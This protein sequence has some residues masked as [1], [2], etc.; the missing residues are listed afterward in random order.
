MQWQAAAYLRL[1]ELYLRDGDYDDAVY[2]YERALDLEPGHQ[3]ALYNLAVASLRGGGDREQRAQRAEEALTALDAKLP[4]SAG[5]QAMRYAADFNRVLAQELVGNRGRALEA[6][7]DLARRVL[8]DVDSGTTD[9][10]VERLEGPATSMLAR[11]TGPKRPAPEDRTPSRADLIAMLETGKPTPMM[12]AAL[13][14]FARERHGEDARTSYDL[15]LLSASRGDP[16]EALDHLEQAVSHPMVKNLV[17]QDPMLRELI[18]EEE[19]EHLLEEPPMT[20]IEPEVVPRR[21]AKVLRATLPLVALALPVCVVAYVVYPRIREELWLAVAVLVGL[22]LAG[23]VAVW[24]RRL[25]EERTSRPESEGS[26]DDVGRLALT[27]LSY[28]MSEVIQGMAAAAAGKRPTG[29]GERPVHP[30][31][32]K[33]GPSARPLNKSG[34]SAPPLDWDVVSE[35]LLALRKESVRAVRAGDLL[36]LVNWRLHNRLVEW[37]APML[38]HPEL[39]AVFRRAAELET[40]LGR[41][42]DVLR[43][44]DRSSVLD[45]WAAVLAEATSL[46]EDLLRA[47]GREIPAWEVA[48]RALPERYLTQLDKRAAEAGQNLAAARALA[49]RRVDRPLG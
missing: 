8:R 24:V 1:G 19:L 27:G 6:A 28:A 43:G 42:Q 13:E 20:G 4:T 14:R 34:P 36:D 9:P 15:A 16:A 30:M 23:V 35:P 5:A 32:G 26:E 41:L 33:S 25:P 21:G 48:R 17:G 3:A 45:E 10:A 31:L 12:G 11:L 49:A 44:D 39:A 7:A 46:R 2:W 47:A 37:S 40:D 38:R 22:A 29:Y 18:P